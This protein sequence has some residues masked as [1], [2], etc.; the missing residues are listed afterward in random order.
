MHVSMSNTSN[1]PIEAMEMEFPLRAERYELIP[2]S[3][4][5]GRQRGGLGVCRDYRILDDGVVLATR[6]T[7]QRFA[8]PGLDGG[9]SGA[10]GAFI[11]DPDT[12]APTKLPGTGSEIPLRKG[13]LL[14]I[15]TAG[16]GGYGKASERGSDQAAADRRN[17]KVT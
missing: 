15:V 10:L 14:R 12:A 11:L 9:D 6:S 8:A 5:P 7:R 13:A 3:G 16:G 1:L 4:G 2:D 17:G